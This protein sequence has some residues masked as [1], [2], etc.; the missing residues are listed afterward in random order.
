MGNNRGRLKMDKVKKAKKLVRNSGVNLNS[1]ALS[2]FNAL[3]KAKQRY[4]ERGVDNQI[5]RIA[6][7]IQPT[8]K[9]ERLL[10]KQLMDVAEGKK[11][12]KSL[13]SKKKGKMEL[14][15][16]EYGEISR[17]FERYTEDKASPGLW[18]EPRPVSMKDFKSYADRMGIPVEKVLVACPWGSS[19]LTDK[20]REEKKKANKKVDVKF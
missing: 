1:Y 9:K 6:S 3:D 10:S 7:N 17:G 20:A 5:K 19:S 11:P 8:N 18:R 4:G 13:K 2:Y 15:E 14:G 12:R 16:I